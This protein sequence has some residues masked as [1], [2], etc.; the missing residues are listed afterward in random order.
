MVLVAAELLHGFLEVPAGRVEGQV[1]QLAK[2]VHHVAHADVLHH[3]GSLERRM[4]HAFQISIDDIVTLNT[5]VKP[6]NEKKIRIKVKFRMLLL[7]YLVGIGDIRADVI[8]SDTLMKTC[9][10][11]SFA[12][13]IRGTPQT[14]FTFVG[15]VQDVLL[16]LYVVQPHLIEERPPHVVVVADG[17]GGKRHALEIGT[18]RDRGSQLFS[19]KNNDLVF[20]LSAEW[21]SWSW[22]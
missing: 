16:L 8:H 13:P 6:I 20:T 9:M 7:L 21:C 3:L 2:L 5:N 17:H 22:G 11:I 15:N 10:Q 14:V 1:D 18:G 4:D 19:A 12:L